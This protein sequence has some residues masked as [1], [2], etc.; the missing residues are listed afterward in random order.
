M[1]TCIV[2]RIIL[3]VS[4]KQGVAKTPRVINDFLSVF[5]FR[6]FLAPRREGI[7]D[8]DDA[9]RFHHMNID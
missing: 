8:E 6:V 7:I 1:T 5:V 2:I 3:P 4:Y 9:L